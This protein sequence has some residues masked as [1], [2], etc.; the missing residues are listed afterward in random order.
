MKY[1]LL[2]AV[3]LVGG[4]VPVLGQTDYTPIFEETDCPFPELD[5]VTC[6][7]LIVPEDRSD[8]AGSTVELA[9]AIIEAADGS[10]DSP[11]IIF[12]EGGPG[13]SPLLSTD[14]FREMPMAQSNE[15]VLIDQRGTGF[16]QPSLNCFELEEDESDD[17]VADC[18]QRL[19]DEGINLSAY[20][21][22]ESAADIND[23]RL[24][25]YGDEQVNLWGISYG[26]RLA[27]T[28]MRNHPEGINAVALDSVFPPEIN[29]TEVLA[30][31]VVSAF[32]NFFNA[33]ATDPDCSAAYPTL[34]QDF[35]E[36]VIA[37]DEQ[38]VTFEYYSSDDESEPFELDGVSVMGGLFQALYNSEAI[39]LLPFGMFILSDP[40]DDFDY[41][42]AVD[43]LSG[44]L[45]VEAWFGEEDGVGSDEPIS[46]SDEVLDYFDQVGDISDSEGMYNSVNCSEEI[47][48]N[49][50]DA[51]FSTLEQLD[52]PFF[53]YVS[54]LVNGAFS[55]CTTWAVEP[56]VDVEAT[57]VE[58]D[59]PTLLISGGF[60]P[61]TPPRYGD[62]ALQ[63]LSNGIHVVF[64][65][66]GHSESGLP[67]CGADL[68]T[69]FFEDPSGNLDTSCIPQSVDWVIE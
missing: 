6:G 19:S 66:G 27:L 4:A 7:V 44:E 15:L 57:R 63:G 30:E 9:V 45:T 55:D 5:R 20:N 41:S 17:P 61:V 38:P 62:S 67:G 46:E 35:Y 24:A 42:D 34:E 8:P 43:I 12:L 69:Q 54:N 65:V 13:G 16:S 48:F 50:Q 51:A 47:P 21:S 33:C 31:V 11:P 32:D 18:Y 56:V 36:T 37:L 52:D 29:E 49:D 28:I 26:T 10:T 39:G 22:T 23:L 1:W 25:L 14:E 68:V 59:I 3:F 58:S 40:L 64:P 60:D 2:L 53:N